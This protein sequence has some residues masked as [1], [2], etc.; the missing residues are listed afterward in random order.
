MMDIRVKRVDQSFFWPILTIWRGYCNPYDRNICTLC[1]GT[2]LNNRVHSTM[3]DLDEPLGQM[4]EITQDY[5]DSLI[6][7]GYLREFNSDYSYEHERYIRRDDGLIV[8]ADEV[9]EIAKLLPRN[10]SIRLIC[11]AKRMIK[12]G[13]FSKCGYCSGKGA[14]WCDDRFDDLYFDW[15]PTEP[16]SGTGYQLWDM[17]HLWPISNVFTDPRKLANY[18]IFELPAL[19]AQQVIRSTP[20]IVLGYINSN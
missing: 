17:E 4:G 15:E 9:H 11:A 3:R 8:T 19:E 1:L 7:R 5:I 20:E 10:A 14:I 12:V 13:A 6:N 2:G 18:V 16:P